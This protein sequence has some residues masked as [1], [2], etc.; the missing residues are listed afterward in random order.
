MPQPY[1]HPALKQARSELLG[2]VNETL[3]AL[4]SKTDFRPEDEKRVA[5]L[6]ADLRDLVATVI[7]TLSASNPGY[8]ERD[9]DVTEKAVLQEIRHKIRI[10]L[11][12]YLP[13]G[14]TEKS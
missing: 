4:I 13:A 5:L 2:W 8:E 10:L 12:T 7:A 9:L 11:A 6:T 3:S 1:L 14:P